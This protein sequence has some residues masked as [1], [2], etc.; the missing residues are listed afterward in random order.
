MRYEG[1]L[2]RVV[3]Q[4][5]RKEVKLEYIW[6]VQLSGFTD[7]LHVGCEKD[8][9]TIFWLE[10]TGLYNLLIPETLV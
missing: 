5:Q 7:G 8:D 4:R 10:A 1:D 2:N 9:I 6:K 3:W